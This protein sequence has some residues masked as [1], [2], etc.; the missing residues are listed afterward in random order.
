M[1]KR[2]EKNKMK[3]KE[4]DKDSSEVK[5][6]QDLKEEKQQ[7]QVEGNEEQKV[8][9]PEAVTDTLESLQ[10]QNSELQDKY[11]RLMA[12]F[13]NFKKRTRQEKLDLINSAG[14]E[15]IVSLLPIVDDMQRGL[16]LS[17]KAEDIKSVRDGFE[18]I[19]N[20]FIG[21]L[22]QKGLESIECKGKEFDTDYH[23]ALTMV[24]NKE[25]KGKVVEEI[26]KGYMLNGKVIRFAKVIVGN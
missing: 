1:S 22:K 17:E 13:E 25:M 4:M 2:K 23:E 16:E 7:D 5:D 26:E 18:L 6:N 9:C 21:I 12:E 20:K 19:Y 14:T 11:V 15:M 10:I 24:E 3:E 8:D